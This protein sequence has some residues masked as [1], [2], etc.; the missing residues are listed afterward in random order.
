MEKSLEQELG[1]VNQSIRVSEEDKQSIS[2]AID[3]LLSVAQRKI[4]DQNTLKYLSILLFT[5]RSFLF[6]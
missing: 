1:L 6:A 2:E 5:V 3:L 4:K